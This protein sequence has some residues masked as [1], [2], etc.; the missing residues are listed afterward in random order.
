MKVRT[1]ITFMKLDSG[2]KLKTIM[3]Q[4]CF[5]LRQKKLRWFFSALAMVLQDALKLH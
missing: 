2:L 4:R 3:C 5:D 1:S